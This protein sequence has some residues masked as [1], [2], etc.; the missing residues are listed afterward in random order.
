MSRFS[1]KTL[2]EDALRL[3]INTIVK[4]EMSGCKMPASRREA[5]WS[6][7]TKYHYKLEELNCRETPRWQSAGIMSFLEFFNS[8]RYK[9]VEIQNLLAT[10]QPE[11]YYPLNYQLMILYRI[12]RQSEQ[13]ISMFRELAKLEGIELNVKEL[14][15][16]IEQR[17][18]NTQPPLYDKASSVW[19]ND[20]PRQDMTASHIT[21][22]KL[23][24]AQVSLLRKAWEIG[25]EEIL[26]QSIIQIDG[27]VTT[28]LSERFAAHQNTFIL[29]THHDAIN[30][31]V[32][33]WSAI[34]KTIGEIATSLVRGSG[35]GKDLLR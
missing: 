16:Q 5:L 2:A 30:T 11:Q 17:S 32:Q 6:L 7:A 35:K 34:V 28:R 19:N 9:S 29:N 15:A 3:E 26:L 23:N 13:I 1:F 21:D 27:D 20:I 8:A 31:S 4:P 25:T 18:G 22:L 14:E 10:A 24:V 12:Q 33:F